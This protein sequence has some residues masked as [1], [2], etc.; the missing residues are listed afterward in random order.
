MSCLIGTLHVSVYCVTKKP[1]LDGINQILKCT[2][3]TCCGKPAGLFSH[4]VFDIERELFLLQKSG[5]N[6]VLAIFS[7]VQTIDKLQ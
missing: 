1:L 7:P 3:R 6:S 5:E 2:M 4:M